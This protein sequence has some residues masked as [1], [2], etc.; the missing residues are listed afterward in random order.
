MSERIE[1]TLAEL[2][3]LSW[4]HDVPVVADGNKWTLAAT[5]GGKFAV[6]T[7]PRLV[8]GGES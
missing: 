8:A 7:A 4:E 3:R 2:E 5:V 6:Y 1:T